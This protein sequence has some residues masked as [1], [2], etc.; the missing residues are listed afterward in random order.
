[1]ARIPKYEKG[2]TVSI[3]A[4]AYKPERLEVEIVSGPH[5]YTDYERKSMAAIRKSLHFE[6]RRVPLHYY[7][8]YSPK[9]GTI[10]APVGQ[11]KDIV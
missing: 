3:A 6:W 9:R 8:V 4:S 10:R 2:K 5:R 11:I 1:M 7:M